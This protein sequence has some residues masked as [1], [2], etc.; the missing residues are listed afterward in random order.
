MTMRALVVDDSKGMRLIL[1]RALR[2][3]GV[4]EVVEATDGQ[5]ALER[6]RASPPVDAVLVDWNMPVMDGLTFV[7]T[8]RADPKI[9]GVPI[10][11][12]TTEAEAERMADALSA[13]ANAYVTK[14]FTETTIR[15]SLERIGFKGR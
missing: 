4:A 5:K 15:D 6:L 11:M 10:V 2:Q 12:V 8:V 9:A 3:F 14:P 13:G 7:K 1:A